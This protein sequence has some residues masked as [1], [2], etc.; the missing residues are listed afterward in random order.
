MNAKQVVASGIVAAAMGLAPTIA[1]AQGFYMTAF[2]G[3]TSADIDERAYDAS[4]VPVLE[5]RG[6][7]VFT[8]GTD[9][10]YYDATASNYASGGGF[11]DSGIGWGLNVGYEF[12]PYVALEV[13]YVDLGKYRQE[14]GSVL[15][16]YTTQAAALPAGLPAAF[17]VPADVSARIISSGPTL[18][19]AGKFPFGPGFSVYGRAGVYFADT[20]VRLKYIGTA[21]AFDPDQLVELPVEFK[22]GTQE[23]FVGL[24]A[25]WDFSE[26]F[27][28]RF[29]AQYFLNVGDDDRTG[30]TDVLLITLGVA[31]R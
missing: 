14:G 4:Y 10:Y 19:V 27:G 20:R 1:A 9:N 18:A 26:E 28:L 29:D 30:E 6:Q 8:D 24:G 2:G 16:T 13:G 5:S 23:I 31:F 7:L 21:A 12:N 25:G 11:D 17:A 15:A 22:A 3:I